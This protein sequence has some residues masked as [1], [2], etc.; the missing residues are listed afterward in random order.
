M[1][2]G[3]ALMRWFLPAA[4]TFLIF[5]QTAAA[6]MVSDSITLNQVGFYPDAPKLAMVKGKRNDGG[7]FV[8]STNL[9]DTFLRGAL[10]PEKSSAYSATV[11][12]AADFSALG[13]PGSYVLLVP[14]LGHSYVFRIAPAV[15]AEVAAASLKGFYFQRMS[16]PL[17]PRFAGKWHRGTGHPDTEVLVHPSAASAARP[18]GFKISMPGGW[19][20][21][22]D[23]N[24]Y[25]VN[26]GIT[27][28][29][30]LS[31]AAD[32]QQ[33]F[34]QQKLA[35][36][37]SGN[38]LPDVIDELLYNLRWMLLMQD[39]NDGGVYHKCTNASFD[40]MVMPGVTTA[41]RYVVQKS[42]A[43]ALNLAAVAA[44]AA[45][46]LQPYAKQLPGL[47][48]TCLQVARK[49]WAW[50][51]Q[52]PAVL[53]NQDSMNKQHKPEVVTGAYG[54]RNLNDEWFWAATELLTTT[55]EATYLPIVRQHFN[56]NMSL[57]SW[58][59]VAAL[60]LYTLAKAT[61]LPTSAN[62][63]PATAKEKIIAFAE[64]MFPAMERSAF[65]TIMG[66]TVRDFA[67]GSSS[68]AANQG[69]ALLHAFRFTGNKKYRDAAISNL[70]YLLGRNATGYSFLTG[71][72]SKTP[73]HPHHRPSV[74]DGIVEPVPGLLS[75][76][77]NPGRQDKCT[78]YKFTE[79]ETAFTDDD[80]SYASNE[81]AI[82]WNAPLVYLVNG[83][84][85]VMR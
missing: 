25:V 16:M 64:G 39:P 83:L 57:P 21:A 51:I 15:H 46:V 40:G 1:N 7:F 31:A 32:Y 71:Y 30:L 12:R 55:G 82:N 3:P 9:R 6:Q 80:C 18:A 60:G 19:Y 68:V 72:G 11:T 85:A 41:P 58:N 2:Y 59:S 8:V 74:A 70:D 79:P 26:S 35:I 23:Y 54:D 22:G 56:N 42:T 45:R 84:E 69:I 36:P 33:Y 77:P 10:G 73:M 13:K 78:T 14:G 20:D 4:F 38:A 17:L 5:S 29:T 62:D 37:E 63:L 52:N 24:K 44:Q 49:A 76:G 66:Q 65:G 47:R 34:A 75:G 50:S 67:W 43:A 48:D 81:I 27:T 61:K 28:A 53:Y